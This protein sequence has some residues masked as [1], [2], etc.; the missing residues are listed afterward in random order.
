MKKPVL[1]IQ[2]HP[3]HK[4]RPLFDFCYSAKQGA[5]E[6]GITVKMFTT[7][8][9]IPSEPHNIVVG[10]VEMCYNWL[11]VNNFLLPELIS[12]LMFKLFLGRQV[13]IVP[14]DQIKYPSFIKPYNNIKAFTGFVAD[15]KLFVD[16]F[17]EGYQGLVLMQEIVDIVSEYRLY[18]NCNK[19][20]GMKHYS[21]DCLIFPDRQFIQ[22]CVDYSLELMDNHSYTLDFG[23][24]TDGSTIL[25]EVND[26]WAC[27]NYGLEPLDYYYC[28]RNR[29]LQITGLRHK[30]EI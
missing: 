1:W 12:L 21:G 11:F 24:L 14:I 29:W 30:M 26:M 17:A 3:Q 19:I 27:G 15:N 20:V 18:I 28:V 4:R 8:K 16:I 7:Y 6:A 10:S 9:N 2:A 5:E 25:I 13:I 22:R 23:V